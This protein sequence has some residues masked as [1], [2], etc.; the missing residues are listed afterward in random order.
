MLQNSNRVF[1]ELNEENGTKL[2]HQK[3]VR[4]H[5]GLK[6]DGFALYVYLR[7]RPLLTSD[8]RVGK[9]VQNDS[10]KSDVTG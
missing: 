10:K 6:P 4:S 7:E 8:F 1:M 2:F 3:V 5:A 9:R